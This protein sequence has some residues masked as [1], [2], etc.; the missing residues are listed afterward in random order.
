MLN[1]KQFLVIML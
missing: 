1:N